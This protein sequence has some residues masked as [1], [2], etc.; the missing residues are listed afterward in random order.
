MK[1]ANGLARHLK[2]LAVVPAILIADVLPTAAAAEV[3]MVP[4]SGSAIAFYAAAATLVCVFVLLNAALRNRIGLYY[5]GLFALMLGL[6]WILDRWSGTV[7]ARLFAGLIKDQGEGGE[8]MVAISFALVCCAA[9]F[10]TAERAIAPDR[11]MKWGRRSLNGLGA[12]AVGLAIAGW[13]L[14]FSLALSLAVPVVNMLLAVMLFSHIVPA[15]T[16]RNLAGKSRRLPAVTAGALFLVVAM[17]FPVYGLSA[18]GGEAC[19]PAWLRWLFA[20]VAVPVMAAIAL[21]VLDLGR[22][23][24]TAL[25]EAVTA[26][27]DR[28]D[29]ARSLLEMEK[30]YASARDIAARQTRRVSTVAHDIRQPIAALRAELDALRADIDDVHADRFA[31]ILDHFDT[32]TGELTT[33]GGIE[34]PEVTSAEDVPAALLFSMLGRLFTSDAAAKGIELRFVSAAATFHA[35][36]GALMRIASNLVSNAITHSGASR[37]LV[38]VRPGAGR[39]RLVVLDDGNGFA[40]GGVDSAR[41]SGIKGPDSGGSGLGLSIVD[42]LADAHGLTVEARTVTGRGTAFTITVPRG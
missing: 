42:E 24:E 37:I 2:A 21:S 38:G 26:A 10:F 22:A 19:D 28:A 7:P 30:N 27:R 6:V 39:V 1:L 41:V 13:F 23:R 15:V 33:E 31:R 18:A 4:V 17:L 32:L 40:G 29:T 8:R 34:S 11:A 14:P 35:P 20:L 12:I 5:A 16:W 3:E 9:G 25:E 36:A